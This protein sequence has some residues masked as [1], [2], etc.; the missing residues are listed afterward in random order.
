MR[1]RGPGGKIMTI[2]T[3]VMPGSRPG[4]HALLE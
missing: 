4:I 3:I 1:G 2:R